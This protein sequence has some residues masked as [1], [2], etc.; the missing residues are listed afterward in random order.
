MGEFVEDA[1]LLKKCAVNFAFGY[2]GALARPGNQG[3][4]EYEFR[5]KGLGHLTGH[6]TSMAKNLA[7]NGN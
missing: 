3:S 2:L 7:E 6:I 5:A 1:R 4:I